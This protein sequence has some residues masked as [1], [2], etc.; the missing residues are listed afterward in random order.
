MPDGVVYVVDDEEC[1]RRAFC[2]LLSSAG[3]RAEG[4]ASAQAFLAQPRMERPACLI[5]DLYLDAGADGLDLQARLCDRQQTIPIIFVTGLPHRF[6][7]IRASVSALKAGAFDFLQK[8]VDREALLASVRSAL[9]LSGEN[10]RAENVRH[11][12]ERRLALLTPREREMLW[13]VVRGGQTNQRMADEMGISV[14]TIKVHRGQVMR[15][16]QAGSVAGLVRMILRLNAGQVRTWFGDD[17]AASTTTWTHRRVT[18]AALDGAGDSPRTFKPTRQAV[19]WPQAAGWA[20]LS[21]AA[22]LLMSALAPLHQ[23]ICVDCGARVLERSRE[24]SLKATKELIANGYAFAGF[25]AC[26]V[27]KEVAPIT[28]LRFN[29]VA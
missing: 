20:M 9:A 25:D 8:P 7:S 1:V 16:M 6:T 10:A 26:E 18:P 17:A 24:E 28:R 5:L 15:K 19:R 3:L 11:L 14:K 22:E 29:E 21:E 23:G 27:C 12:V 2:R 4:F 13:C